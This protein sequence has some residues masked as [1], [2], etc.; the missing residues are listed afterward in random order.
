MEFVQARKSEII[1]A[2]FHFRFLRAV[3]QQNL[4]TAETQSVNFGVFRM[5]KFAYYAW[6]CF[7]IKLVPFKIGLEESC[8]YGYG[9]L[10][11]G[12]HFIDCVNKFVHCF[13]A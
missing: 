11:G 9:V 1:S 2:N 6:T 7:H 8:G 3:K 5:P 12:L 4:K 10:Y 13:L